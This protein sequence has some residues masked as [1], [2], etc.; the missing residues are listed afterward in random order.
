[1]WQTIEAKQRFI[2]QIMTSKSPVRSCEDIDE[3]ALSY[4]EVKALATGNPHIKEKMDLE[5]D[6][7]RLKLI[8][9]N[10]QSQKYALEDALI[11]RFPADIR[12]TA[13]RMAGYQSDIALYEQHK[14][15]DFPGMMLSGTVFSEK[16]D[17]GVELIGI[18]KVQTSPAPKH[19]GSYRGFD[20]ILAYNTLGKAFELT[21]KGELS[22]SISLGEDIHGNIQRIENLLESLPTRLASCERNLGEL[23]TQAENAKTEVEK[24]F[25]QEDE[26]KTKTARLAELDA[27]L[28]MDRRENDTLDA[29]PEQEEERVRT[30]SEPE[31]ER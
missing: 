30:R 22:H 2:A 12:R 26:L 23:Q 14:S 20:L 27:M 16:K 31:H 18:C 6:V 13:E 10:Y 28:N 17:A 8:K 7:A 1:M 15:E 29:E 4:A 9:A 3:T 21:L 24:P 11:K 19:I 5:I 25:A